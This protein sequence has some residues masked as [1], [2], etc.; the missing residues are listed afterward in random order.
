MWGGM[1]QTHTH[2]KKKK[3]TR[4]YQSGDTYTQTPRLHDGRTA[5]KRAKRKK[6]KKYLWLM[7]PKILTTSSG[8]CTG[9]PFLHKHDKRLGKKQDMRLFTE[10]NIRVCLEKIDRIQVTGIVFEIRG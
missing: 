8:R 7:D 10:G 1:K 6:K 5:A 2:K 9:C 3:S 4:A